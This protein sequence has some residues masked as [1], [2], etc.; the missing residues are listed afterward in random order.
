MKA[1]HRQKFTPRIAFV[2]LFSLIFLIIALWNYGCKKDSEN[3]SLPQ[4]INKVPPV[5]WAVGSQDS[6]SRASVFYSADSGSN[7]FRQGAASSALLNFDAFDLFVTDTNNVWVVG[8]NRSIARTR[9][10]GNTWTQVTPPAVSPEAEFLSIS[11]VKDTAIWISGLGPNTGFVCMS[12]DDGASWSV[13]ESDLFQHYMMQGVMALNAQ[14]IYAVGNRSDGWAGIICR[15]LDGGITWDS[16]SLPD[17]YS[18]R[19]SWIGVTATDEKHVVVYGQKNHY[20]YT[21]DGGVTWEND[22]VVFS[23]TGQADINH[24]IML[25]H[26]SWW[27]ALD[28]GNIMMTRD[29][30]ENWTHQNT[31]GINSMYLMGIDAYDENIAVVVGQSL[32]W[33]KI[34]GILQTTDGGDNWA[35]RKA[36]DYW[37][38]KV[39]FAPH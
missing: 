5:A 16:I 31:S 26:Q 27:A 3:P 39:A 17:N 10:G 11:I 28:M 9:D 7:W 12:D 38:F 15:T 6:T 19:V 36:T 23:G 32:S 25:D 18:K 34:G 29:G 13:M 4:G 14:V 20:T 21:T 37:M 30:G 1:L 24:L 2:P 35:N 33:P 22:S 8:T